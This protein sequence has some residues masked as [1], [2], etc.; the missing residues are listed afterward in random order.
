MSSISHA[1]DFFVEKQLVEKDQAMRR[2]ALV[3]R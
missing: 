1:K 2:T 3:Q